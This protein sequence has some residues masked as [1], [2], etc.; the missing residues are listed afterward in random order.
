MWER[1]ELEA[2]LRLLESPGIGW[3]TA[4]Q[5]LARHGSPEAIF[6]LSAASATSPWF[7]AAP[8]DWKYGR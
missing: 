2:W 3:V 1:D 5:L 4:R 6:A 8:A 7:V